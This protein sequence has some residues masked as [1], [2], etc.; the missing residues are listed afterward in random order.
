MGE[1]IFEQKCTVKIV[2]EGKPELTFE[3]DLE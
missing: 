3:A 2:E 1:I